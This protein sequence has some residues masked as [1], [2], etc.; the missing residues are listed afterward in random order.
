MLALLLA[1]EEGG[2]D[3]FIHF[4]LLH[5]Q[6]KKLSSEKIVFLMGLNGEDI[7]RASPQGWSTGGL[8]VG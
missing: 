5:K 2:G 3:E 8:L 4:I 7:E 1:C 6:N